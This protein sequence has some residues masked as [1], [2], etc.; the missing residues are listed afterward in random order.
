MNN[1]KLLISYDGGRFKGWQK[2]GG[3]EL[4]VQGIIEQTISAML[5]YPVEIHGSGRTDAGVHAK[6]QVANMKTPFLLHEN[7]R[8]E[9]NKVLPED[10]CLLKVERINGTFHARYSAKDKTYQYLVDTREKANVF[11]R[12]YAYHFPE[13]LD[14][15]KMKAAGAVLIGTH[16]FTSFTNDKYS[17]KDKMRT[18]YDIQISREN[19]VIKFVYRGD[20][21]LQN[22]VRIITGTLLEVGIGKRNSEEV[23]KILEAKERAMAGFMV[24]AQGLFLQKVNYD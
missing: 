11:T 4:T 14:I 16:D 13:Q 12:K 22:M 18:I 24:P 19:D 15:E 5:G 6:G 23:V 7:F 10:V 1:Y 21:F 8:E 2:L 20:G 3:G 9:L 17:G